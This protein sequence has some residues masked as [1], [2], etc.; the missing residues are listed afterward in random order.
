M[1]FF[2]SLCNQNKEKKKREHK[3]I[4]RYS[5]VKKNLILKNVFALLPVPL[6]LACIHI[7][8]KNSVF[9]MEIENEQRNKCH[10]ADMLI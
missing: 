9:M 6:L 10:L 8:T 7:T 2:F 3:T 1:M 4:Q 5:F